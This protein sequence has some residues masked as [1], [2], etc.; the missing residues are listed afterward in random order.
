MG[1]RFSCVQFLLV[2]GWCFLASH[3]PSG[4]VPVT[5]QATTPLGDANA[6]NSSSTDFVCDSQCELHQRAALRQLYKETDLDG[7]WIN[8]TG[9]DG[10]I[11][12]HYCCWFG[13]FC[14]PP[15]SHGVNDHLSYVA[16][17]GH[18]SSE[19][20]CN[21][22][23]RALVLFRN[24]L[25]GELP[26]QSL[27]NLNS[28]MLVLLDLEF[29]AL[30]G[31]LPP[32][33]AQLTSLR[34]L[35]MSFNQLSG[36]IPDLWR[37]MADLSILQLSGNNL[38]GSVP[39]DYFSNLANLR[40]MDIMGNKLTGSPPLELISLPQ[41]ES[42][43]G[44]HNEFN[45]PL[46]NIEDK[47][48]VLPIVDL[49]F[50]NI[51]GTL[52]YMLES[53]ALYVLDLSA[54]QLTGSIPETYG[55]IHRLILNN[56]NLNGSLVTLP[57]TGTSMLMLSHNQLTGSLCTDCF[58]VAQRLRQFEISNNMG[59]TGP[60]P[61]IIPLIQQL[62][63]SFTSMSSATL[64]S[65]WLVKDSTPGHSMDRVLGVPEFAI[66][67]SYNIPRLHCGEGPTPKWG[68]LAPYTP[69]DSN[70]FY[71][72]MECV[73]PLPLPP[74]PE[75]SQFPRWAIGI[76]IAVGALTLAGIL[77]YFFQEHVR[78]LLASGRALNSKKK[79]PGLGKKTAYVTLVITD[80]EA[81]TELWEWDGQDVIS[82]SL[83]LSPRQGDF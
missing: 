37:E 81:S 72:N 83:A 42:L 16:P 55:L 2:V 9:W 61:P 15:E 12:S 58:A 35:R 11:D 76:T 43:V 1:V 74:P 38:S 60:L 48:G 40:M 19:S 26:V 33:L 6:L 64:K 71:T 32:A 29:N 59:I 50:N 36:S 51:P 5:S 79:P 65:E 53:A 52:P 8:S 67:P 66:C 22:G 54:N 70:G 62:D 31:T 49:S 75:V 63:I 23:V 77:I 13:V 27:V 14:C 41:F 57:S 18:F 28:S 20:S 34:D 73:V 78:Q 68:T 7:T 21:G 56:N 17:G 4:P 80:V 3:L 45:A 44:S 10:K 47:T 46:P 30:Y 24:G 82:S 39:F 25:A 69:A